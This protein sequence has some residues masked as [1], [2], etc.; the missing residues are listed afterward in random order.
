MGKIVLAVFASV[1]VSSTAMSDEGVILEKPSPKELAKA[2][3]DDPAKARAKYVRTQMGMIDGKPMVE[4]SGV[5]KKSGMMTFTIETDQ[6]ISI[7]LKAKK[8][9][10]N[11]NG[12]KGQGYVVS[13]ANNKV[14]IECDE[15]E[16]VKF[17]GK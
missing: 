6:G 4:L 17:V 1:L 15:V 3:K 2:F 5:Y 11:G 7:V 12:V 9:K 16:L 14:V 13:F 10:G 8:V